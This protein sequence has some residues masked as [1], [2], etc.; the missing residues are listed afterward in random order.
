[1]LKWSGVILTLGDSLLHVCFWAR[2]PS[3]THV[4]PTVTDSPI[5]FP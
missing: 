4:S 1:M 3:S 5:S 2:A